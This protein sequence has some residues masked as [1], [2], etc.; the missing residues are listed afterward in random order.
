MNIVDPGKDGAVLGR[1]QGL[2]G[3]AETR[4]DLDVHRLNTSDDNVFI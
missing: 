3:F 2:I 4:F 1:R